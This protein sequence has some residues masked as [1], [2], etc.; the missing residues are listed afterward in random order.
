MEKQ[1]ELL[2]VDA[3]ATRL[4]CSAKWI[5]AAAEDGRLPAIRVGRL[6]RFDPDEID[7]WIDERRTQPRSP[8]RAA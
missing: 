8:E 2:D 7:A 1:Q 6:L 4:N 3:L 5:Y